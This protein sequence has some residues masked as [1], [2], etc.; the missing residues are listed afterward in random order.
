MEKNKSW[1]KQVTF[2]PIGQLYIEDKWVFLYTTEM[3]P[4]RI[5]ELK[6]TIDKGYTAM[7]AMNNL[8]EHYK[9]VKESKN[10]TQE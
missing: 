1:P 2:D 9:N 6:R 7:I 8:E 3:D 4:I 10:T 5:K